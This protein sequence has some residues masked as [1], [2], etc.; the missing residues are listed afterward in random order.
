MILGDI[1]QN[2]TDLRSAYFEVVTVWLKSDLLITGP[3]RL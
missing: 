3:T 1:I 2:S